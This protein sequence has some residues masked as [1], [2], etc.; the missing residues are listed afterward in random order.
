MVGIV[1]WNF[2]QLKVKTQSS[3]LVHLFVVVLEQSPP[4]SFFYKMI[5]KMEKTTPKMQDRSYCPTDAFKH[6]AVSKI[7]ERQLIIGLSDQ[8]N[9]F[10]LSK[11]LNSV[12]CPSPLTSYLTISLQCLSNPVGFVQFEI[13]LSSFHRPFINGEWGVRS[14]WQL[15]IMTHT[16]ISS[17]P[18][19]LNRTIFPALDPARESNDFL[20][21]ACLN[22]R[23]FEIGCL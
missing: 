10:F 5:P 16:E 2:S 7:Q 23:T 21:D 15:A 14:T 20:S 22:L 13:P 3:N 1:K 12:S 17:H 11:Y 18:L 4:L 6:R 8:A 9:P 19:L